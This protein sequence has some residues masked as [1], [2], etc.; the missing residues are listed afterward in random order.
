MGGGS[1]DFESLDI[2]YLFLDFGEKARFVM[3]TFNENNG[4]SMKFNKKNS[5]LFMFGKREILYF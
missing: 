3:C 5:L 1:V 2:K 4:E